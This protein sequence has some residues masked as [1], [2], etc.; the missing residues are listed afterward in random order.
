MRRIAP[1][2]LLLLILLGSACSYVNNFVVVNASTH[3]IEVWYKVKRPTD[4]GVSIPLPD[5]A[6]FTKSA[7]QI[8]E[9]VAWQQLP[10]TR[11]RIDPD[12]RTVTL[13]LN[14]GEALLL[15]QCSPAGGKTSGDCEAADFEID[16]ITLTG[17]NGEIKLLGE[18][19]HKS[20][21]AESK[22][23]YTLRY[24]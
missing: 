23:L 20:F 18:Q 7:S 12:N 16:A 17:A 4:S 21:V 9:Q 11:Y 10:S 1:V 13:T 6:P 19:A 22:R 8:N 3:A 15:D 14:P 2:L 5:I 24:N